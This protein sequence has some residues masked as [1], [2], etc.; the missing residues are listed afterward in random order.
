MR[1][2]SS[3]YLRLLIF[4]PTILIPAY[5][6]SSPASLMMYSAY[7]LINMVR[8]YSLM[9]SFSYL[10]P[11]CW[12]ISSSTCC[13]LSWIQVFQEAGQM[14]WHSHLLQNF[15]QFSRLTFVGKIM[16]LLL[17]MLSRLVITFLPWSNCLLISWLKP[18]PA[19]ILEPKKIKSDIVSTVTPS[20]CHE[21]MGPDAMWLIFWMLSFKPTFHSPLYL[22]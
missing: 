18:P 1:V 19:V 4:L 7:K 13:I 10:E 11:V 2:V 3:A 22:S 9:F 15:P 6:T 20:I 5:A 21:V 17:N 14:L 12:S 16:S 8:I